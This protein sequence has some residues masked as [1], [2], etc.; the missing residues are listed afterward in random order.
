MCVHH[1]VS[2]HCFKYFCCVCCYGVFALHSEW[3]LRA[4]T[5]VLLKMLR[6]LGSNH[7]NDM[8]KSS[9]S[10][11]TVAFSVIKRSYFKTKSR[12]DKYF[13]NNLKPLIQ[14]NEFDVVQYD[15]E[16][17]SSKVKEVYYNLLA[18]EATVA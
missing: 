4:G 17:L 1:I 5:I 2:T 6:G 11:F 7:F 16:V 12:L 10:K 14:K 13:I 15:L 18:A 9:P 3:N 8:L